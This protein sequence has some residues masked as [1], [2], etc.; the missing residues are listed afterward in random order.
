MDAKQRIV[1]NTLAQHVRSLFNISLSLFSTRLI[2]QALGA[3]DYGIWS[4]VSGVVAMLAFVTNALVVTTQRNLSFY[5]GKNDEALLHRVFAS[6]LLLH[7]VIAA[8]AAIVL[9]A[10]T[11]WLFGG[12]LVIAPERL[13][14]ARIVYYL[15]VANVLLVFLTAPYRG[16]FFARENIVYISLVDMIDG[17]LKLALAIALFYISADKLAVYSLLMAGITLFNLLA[18]GIYA[19]RKFGEARL[20]FVRSDFDRTLIR[21]M[22]GFASWTSYSIGC[23]FARTQGI[24]IILNRFFGTVINASYGIAMQVSGSVQFVAL[25]VTN[26]MSPQLYKSE[27][28]HDRERMWA[29]AEMLS[30]YSFLMF[31]MVAVP[32]AF[33]MPQLLHIWLGD[34]PDHCV[35]FCRFILISA[36]CD[37]LTTG[38]VA[39]NQAIGRIMAYTLI[40]NN[41]KILTLPLAFLGLWIGAGVDSVMWAFLAMEC[42]CCLARLPF[43]RHTAALNV[44]HF[45]KAVFVRSLAPTAV[46]L[47]VCFAMVNLLDFAWRFV[48]TLPVA[49]LAHIASIWLF[50]LTPY[51]RN[52]AKAMILRHKNN[53][54]SQPHAD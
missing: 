1:V 51:E 45:L 12:F 54:S 2:L 31:S 20:H 11:P 30:K 48:V 37:Q 43:M 14:V 36:V 42:V 49:V 13:A 23:I 28:A 19:S 29:I 6:S 4:L 5:R 46:L 10:L 27:G 33:E 40:I 44:A 21:Q 7:V 17:V 22:S 3:G 50:G 9:L 52:M 16:L 24:A 32:L 38:L 47:I 8:A 53:L 41:I 34:V 18:F 25:A 39:A 26:A 15:T 35:M